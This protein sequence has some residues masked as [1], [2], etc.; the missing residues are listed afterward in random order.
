M[1]QHMRKYAAL[2][3]CIPNL[4]KKYAKHKDVSTRRTQA[5]DTQSLQPMCL[6]RW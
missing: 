4:L 2:L 3:Y 5:T 1:L 6:Y